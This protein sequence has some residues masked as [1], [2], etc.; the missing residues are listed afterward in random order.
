VYGFNIRSVSSAEG[1][2]A[3]DLLTIDNNGTDLMREIFARLGFL[4]LFR[5]SLGRD[6]TLALL[7]KL[8]LLTGL[9]AIVSRLA[10]RPVNTAAATADAV[11]GI[12]GPGAAPR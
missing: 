9:I 2:K 12:G 4:R 8:I 5:S 6:V 1:S 10:I 3:G 11:A 7:L